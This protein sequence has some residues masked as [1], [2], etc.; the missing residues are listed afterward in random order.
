L[1]SSLIKGWSESEK[2]LT[3]ES[4][5]PDTSNMFSDRRIQLL[6]NKLKIYKQVLA[7]KE[8]DCAELES[9]E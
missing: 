3:L 1:S 9:R 6:K 7:K 5:V 4:V 2:R 8:E